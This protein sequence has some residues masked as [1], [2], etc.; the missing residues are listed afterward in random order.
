MVMMVV[1][2]MMVIV[3]VMIIMIIIMAVVMTM[4]IFKGKMRILMEEVE[5]DDHAK[6]II[7]SCC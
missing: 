2:T 7:C 4:T 6:M 3:T 5:D 1:M